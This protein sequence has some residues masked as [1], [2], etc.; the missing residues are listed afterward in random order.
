MIILLI[1]WL[2]KIKLNCIETRKYLDDASFE[3]LSKKIECDVWDE[4]KL[5]IFLHDTEKI[6][7]DMVQARQLIKI[8]EKQRTDTQGIRFIICSF[9]YD[10]WWIRKQDFYHSYLLNKH[11]VQ[12]RSA[13]EIMIQYKAIDEKVKVF[14]SMLK[15]FGH[16][17]YF[18]PPLESTL[19]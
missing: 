10:Y 1:T 15:V 16:A 11:A 8:F 5:Y 6:G 9:V 19:E 12:P 14:L 2:L 13:K 3:K 18:T 7:L 4:E 17:I